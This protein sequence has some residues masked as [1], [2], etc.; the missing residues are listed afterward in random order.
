MSRVRAH[1]CNQPHAGAKDAACASGPPRS[2][3]TGVVGRAFSDAAEAEEAEPEEPPPPPPLQARGEALLQLPEA[4]VNYES[5][6]EEP[7]MRLEARATCCWCEPVTC[8]VERAT[9]QGQS[10][11]REIQII[12]CSMQSA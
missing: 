8:E 5:E 9:S 1:G 12:P 10:S 11:S 7:S 2:A 6:E 4:V 3:S